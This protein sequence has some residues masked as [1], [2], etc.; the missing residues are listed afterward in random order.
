MGQAADRRATEPSRHGRKSPQDVALLHSLPKNQHTGPGSLGGPRL[1]REQAAWSQ[2]AQAPGSLQPK[3][4]DPEVKAPRR[5]RG[6]ASGQGCWLPLSL[7][8]LLRCI[9]ALPPHRLSPALAQ[10]TPLSASATPAASWTDTHLPLM[11]L[12]SRIPSAGPQIW[13]KSSRDI[14]SKSAPRRVSGL[15]VMWATQEGSMPKSLQIPHW[16]AQGAS[17]A[18]GGTGHFV[19]RSSRKPNIGSP[20]NRCPQKPVQ[21]P[22]P[23]SLA[24]SACHACTSGWHVALITCALVCLQNTYPWQQPP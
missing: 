14:F 1:P 2:T 21:L 7:R 24:L 11:A 16:G 20:P 19:E 5:P 10:R 6:R 4:R 18:S 3:G 22:R 9:L 15:P 23:R 17:L 12:K 13:T 8:L